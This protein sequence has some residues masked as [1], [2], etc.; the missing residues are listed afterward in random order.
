MPG[1]RGPKSLLRSQGKTK[2]SWY[3]IEFTLL[4]LPLY[5]TKDQ[6]LMGGVESGEDEDAQGNRGSSAGG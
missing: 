6:I 4:R 1:M 3:T 2:C 5:L